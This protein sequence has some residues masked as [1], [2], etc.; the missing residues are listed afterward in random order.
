MPG[1]FS[2]FA[3]D[4]NSISDED[5]SLPV[6]KTETKFV[7]KFFRVGRY[8][9]VTIDKAEE[10]NVCSDPTW[11]TLKIV[12]KQE[13]K[14]IFHFVKIPTSKLTYT[15][16]DGKE[17]PF[18]WKQ[19]QFF[20]AACGIELT[21]ETAGIII[22]SLASDFNVLV[23]MKLDIVVGHDKNYAAY[24]A[25]DKYQ[26]FD[27]HNKPIL[28]ADGV[29]PLEFPNPAAA[30]S[31]CIDTLG[32]TFSDWPQVKSMYK[33]SANTKNIDLK[34]EKPEPKKKTVSVPW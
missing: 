34:K 15:T 23:G 22:P 10:G 29:N 14:E 13:E 21:K 33:S 4:I 20:L 18:A 17:S 9:A 2:K 6:R 16:K 31:F 30:K 5:A 8:E 3:I 1:K 24:I 12:L 19:L 32:A 27:A 7:Q 11:F 28:E 25:K 26:L